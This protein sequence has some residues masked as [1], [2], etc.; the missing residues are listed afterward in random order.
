M[1]VAR[2]GPENLKQYIKEHNNEEGDEE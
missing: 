2:N 1:I